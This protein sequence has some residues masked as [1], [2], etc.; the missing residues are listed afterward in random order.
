MP[1]LETLFTEA[2]T[3]GKWSDQKVS[4]ETLNDLYDLVKM[5][6]TAVNSC[7][8]RFVFITTPEAKARLIPCMDEGNRKK[9]LEAPVNVI[10]AY[11]LDFPTKLGKLFPHAPDAESWFD[12]MAP[13]EIRTVARRNMALQTGYFIIAARA[14]GLDVGPMSGFN[15]DTLNWEFLRKGEKTNWFSDLVINLGYGDKE[16]LH[17]RGPRL[18]FDEAALIL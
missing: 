15:D 12:N 8:A 1:S 2:R 3:F 6:P 11:D 13:S 14:L 4:D 7:P 5:G 16:S 9:T 17:P 10:V 18:S